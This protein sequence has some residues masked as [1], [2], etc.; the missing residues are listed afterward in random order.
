M[1]ATDLHS[2]RHVESVPEMK[3]SLSACL[4]QCDHASVREIE[5]EDRGVRGEDH[6][7]G[8]SR[9]P[10]PSCPHAFSFSF[11]M[12][13]VS[14]SC[15]ICPQPP[16]LA[17]S[18]DGQLKLLLLMIDDDVLVGLF[19]SSWFAKP[20]FSWHLLARRPHFLK[21]FLCHPPTNGN[22]KIKSLAVLRPQ[23]VCD[24]LFSC[25]LAFLVSQLGGNH[26]NHEQSLVASCP[27]MSASIFAQA[28]YPQTKTKQAILFLYALRTFLFPSFRPSFSP[29]CRTS[30]NQDGQA[31]TS[32]SFGHFISVCV[33]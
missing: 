21:I 28:T 7:L 17:Q 16:A 6:A 29:L 15:A 32:R 31:T 10:S 5:R 19:S 24:F 9:A 33:C 14:V 8:Q 2:S 22:R 3:S 11:L 20:I 18:V 13:G 1:V 26:H 30:W 27:F 4:L 23:Y 12:P 25:P